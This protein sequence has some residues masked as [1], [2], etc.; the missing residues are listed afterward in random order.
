[1]RFFH[2]LFILFSLSFIYGCSGKFI[3]NVHLANYGK[4]GITFIKFPSKGLPK[5][6]RT[7]IPGIRADVSGL[8]GGF[9]NDRYHLPSK[10]IEIVWQLNEL[11]DC[12]SVIGPY[13]SNDKNYPGMFSRKRGCTWTPL[14]DKI[15]RKTI[16]I[17]ALKKSEHFKRSGKNA[18]GFSLI[19][20]FAEKRIMSI[21]L[22]FR[23]DE[24]DVNLSSRITNPWK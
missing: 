4:Y 11:T 15:F 3:Y 12:D 21:T 8:M 16:D 18:D 13:E 14:P 10:P 6:R 1:M 23:D 22:V 7:G 19:P 17:E 2:I 24:M 5:R 9:N 20:R